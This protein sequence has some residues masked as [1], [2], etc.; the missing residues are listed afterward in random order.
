MVLADDFLLEAHVVGIGVDSA[1][2]VE[3]LHDHGAA[4]VCGG[5][6]TSHDDPRT[7][8]R[9][10]ARYETPVPVIGEGSRSPGDAV[11]RRRSR[12]DILVIDVAVRWDKPV[13]V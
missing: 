10:G 2:D 8:R 6:G 3:P 9:G 12:A 13:A 1:A 7:I 11:R 4:R 5:G